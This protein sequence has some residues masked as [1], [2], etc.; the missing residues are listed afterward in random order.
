M[1]EYAIY[2]VKSEKWQEMAF[3]SYDD[4]VEKYGTVNRWDYECVYAFESKN[5]LSLDDIYYIFN[6]QRPGD[7]NAHSLSVSDVVETPDGFYYCDSF[8]WIKLDW[9]RWTG[10]I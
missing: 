6:M 1:A 9:D 7:F 2:N 3:R 10:G 8:G 5:A 4:V